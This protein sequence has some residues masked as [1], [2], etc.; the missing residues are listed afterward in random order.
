M[1][2]YWSLSEFNKHVYLKLIYHI[3]SEVYHKFHFFDA[4]CK[5][6]MLIDSYFID[7]NYCSV[8][9]L[10]NQCSH[11]GQQ[12]MSPNWKKK[13]KSELDTYTKDPHVGYVR[14]DED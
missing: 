11:T 4:V 10:I 3:Q 12:W 14:R 7:P 1:H 6:D 8:L 9:D 13:R 2:C 5:Y